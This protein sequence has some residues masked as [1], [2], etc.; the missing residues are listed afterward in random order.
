MKKQKLI[1]AVSVLLALFMV[2]NDGFSQRG[3]G[4]RGDSPHMGQRDFEPIYMRIPDLTDSQMDKLDAYY[5]TFHS[6]AQ[7]LRSKV[8]EKSIQL[9]NEIIKDNADKSKINQ[10][11]DEISGLRAELMKMRL[12]HVLKIRSELNEKQKIFMDNRIQMIAMKGP[13]GGGFRR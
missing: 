13:H 10:M 3:K 12:D 8:Q 1:F 9:K 2:S 4:R 7:P 11:V 5:V 6:S